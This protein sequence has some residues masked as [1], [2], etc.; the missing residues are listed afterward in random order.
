[1][2]A[3]PRR[4]CEP[5]SDTHTWTRHLSLCLMCVPTTTRLCSL[6]SAVRR[7]RPIDGH[8]RSPP[9]TAPPHFLPT[10]RRRYRLGV[11]RLDGAPG[12]IT[13]A[14]RQRARP[15]W[16]A[17]RQGSANRRWSG[18]CSAIDHTTSASRSSSCGD[19]PY[20]PLAH[21]LGQA[22]EGPTA[23]VAAD[24]AA[25]L[26]GDTLVIEDAHWC[27]G[28]TLE[29]LALLAGHVPL[30][31][32]TRTPL[33]IERHDRVAVVD[34]PPLSPSAARRSPASC[35]RPSTVRVELEAGRA[36]RR[37]PPAARAARQRRRRLADA[38]PRRAVTGHGAAL[39]DDRAARRRRPARPATPP[40][41]PRRRRRRG[42]ARGGH[43][44]RA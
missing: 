33:A 21:A 5:S 4:P 41:P 26:G 16:C 15:W 43:G 2:R 23:D 6:R 14:A 35:T 37:Q 25:A 12:R 44:T 38:G 8:D 39:R 3:R 34:V 10:S 31:V 1:M 11:A 24:V 19:L 9:P 7:G 32:T 18:E 36:G 22:F 40:P 13:V 20:H 27:D 28:A 17:G 42:R 29:V 30:V